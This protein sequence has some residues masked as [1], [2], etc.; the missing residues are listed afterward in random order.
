MPGTV[1]S[2][3]RTQQRTEQTKP[4]SWGSFLN[5]QKYLIEYRL[6]WLSEWEQAILNWVARDVLVNGQHGGNT[7]LE[8][9]GDVHSGQREQPVQ[10]L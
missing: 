10:N 3:L 1:S 9:V 8:G 7:H 5:H 2:G 6:C 4:W